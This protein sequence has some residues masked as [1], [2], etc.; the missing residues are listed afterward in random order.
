MRD[1]ADDEFSAATFRSRAVERGDVEDWRQYGDHVLNLD[2][3][4]RLAAQTL[5]DA[6]VLVPLVDHG[7]R[8]G[9]LLTQRTAAMRTHSGQI[10]FPGGAVDPDDPSIE[11]AAMR[12]ADEEIGL[13]PSAIEPVGR[14]PHY[15][16]VTGFRITP[17]LAVIRGDYSMT[18][19][20]QEVDDAFE[21][22]FDFL[23][24]PAN[25]NRE[26]RF[27]EGRERHFYAMPYKDRYI[28]G[29]TAGILRTLYE[30]HYS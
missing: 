9:V 2:I 12:E 3:A 10:A 13:S 29:V 28:W 22:P 20:R 27:W 23:M 8:T 16:T 14:L 7:D 21:V 6:A 15:L 25:H 30:R 19:N 5:R 11:A 4:E 18:L 26:S 1:V 24:N 17:V